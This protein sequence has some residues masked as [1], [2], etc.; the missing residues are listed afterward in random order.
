M[1]DIP[2]WRA[3]VPKDQ[4]PA[5]CPEF[6][7]NL[8]ERDQQLVGQL[9]K[10]YHRLTWPEV[11]KVIADNQLDRFVR[12]PSDLRRYL[13]YNAQLKKEHGS[14]MDYVVKERLN[15]ID[16]KPT[17]AAPFTDPHTTD[18]KILYNDW[19]YGID[20]RI[21]HLVVWTKFDLPD[22]PSTKELALDMRAQ[23]DDYVDKT[24]CQA[25]PKENVI[26]F[27]NWKALKSI[28]SVEHFHVMLFDPDPNL[29]EEVTH[30]DIPLSRKM[31]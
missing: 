2:Y 5:E 3:N 13:E 22:D 16:L 26:W 17:D 25:V 19:P 11:K 30:G 8:S 27:K 21:V 24:F 6:L 7:L 10:D 1:E 18:I 12:V 4:W 28:H 31:G 23:I 15:W 14:V 29:I 9:D 20:E